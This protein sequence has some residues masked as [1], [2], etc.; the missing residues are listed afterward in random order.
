MA[1]L[2]LRGTCAESGRSPR[3]CGRSSPLAGAQGVG[4]QERAAGER[5]AYRD[6]GAVVLQELLPGFELSRPGMVKS[7]VKEHRGRQ[8]G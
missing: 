4:G 7:P 1:R 5:V 2:L 3:G 8:D 6:S